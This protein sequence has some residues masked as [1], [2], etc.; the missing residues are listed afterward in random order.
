MYSQS[1]NK[2]EFSFGVMLVPI[3]SWDE[4][5]SQ[6]QLLEELEFDKLWL[7]DHFVNSA[8][9]DLD[10]FECWTLLSALALKTRKIRI[11]TLVSSMTL[12]NPALLAR[13][14]LTVDHVSNGRLELGVGSSGASYCHKMTGIPQWSARERSLR[15]GEFV[16]ILDQMLENEVTTYEGQ[17]YSIQEAIIHPRPIQQPHPPLNIAAHGPR[18]LRLAA[19]HGDG[20]NSYYP[21]KD[22]TPKESSNITRQRY[23]ML[24]EFAVEAGR[25]P[26]EIGCTFLFGY[27]A[28]RPFASKDAFFD[29]VGRYSEAGIRDFCFFY[30]P[31][32]DHLADQSI[33]N[34]DL[35]QWVTLEAI[36]SIQS[37]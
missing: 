23:E 12:R 14:A 35:L 18:S 5:V 16:A 22:L 33:T 3:Y 4:L 15:F 11:G 8:K 36:P 19:L 28:D 34:I 32:I 7:P 9:P 27:T 24:K 13:M 10:W 21:G 29:A 25:D 20:W 31:G 1:E 37:H 6:A 30:Q 2:R 26:A 17:Y